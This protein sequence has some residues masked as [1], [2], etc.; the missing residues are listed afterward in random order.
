MARALSVL[1]QML[2]G[3][4]LAKPCSHPGM[5]EIRTKAL[6][7]KVSGKIQITANA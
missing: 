2:T 1:I 4:L 6:E 3:W 7:T 5:E